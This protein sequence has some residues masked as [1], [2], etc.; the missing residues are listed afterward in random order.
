MARYYRLDRTRQAMT[1]YLAGTVVA[2]IYLGWHFAVDLVGGAA[3]AYGAVCLGRLMVYP[4][5]AR[6]CPIPDRS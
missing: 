1:L 5:R 4:Q 2:T 3:I 6:R